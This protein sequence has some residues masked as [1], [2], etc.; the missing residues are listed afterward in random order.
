MVEQLIA[1]EEFALAD[2]PPDIFRIGT[3]IIGP[4]LIQ[5][6]RP[7]QKARFLPP[8]VSGEHLWCQGFSEPGA[9]SDLAALTT[10]AA[11]DGAGFRISGQK[12]WN[13]FGHWA[14]YCL[15]LVRTDPALPKHKGL[16]AFVVEMRTPGIQV[17][18]LVQI[19]GEQDFNELFFDEVHVREEA[20][21]GRL[22]GGWEVAV[23]MLGHERR[24]IAVI[25]F[26]CRQLYGRLLHLAREV[27]LGGRGI[28]AIDDA[29]VRSRL[30]RFGV[31]VRLIT[32]NNFRF[33][34]RIRHGGVPG[35]EGSIQKLQATELSKQM[36]AFAYELA[37]AGDLTQHG[38]AERLANWGRDYLSAFG[39]TIAGGTS[40]IQR[41]I[42]GERALGLP[43]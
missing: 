7:E 35:P 14:D 23:T 27:R 18:P 10:R 37:T 15:L 40:Q 12:V 30:A 6:G 28:A 22:N 21:V 19:N 34:E 11:R 24:G 16:T 8:M 31:Q 36:Y 3:R 9:G 41:N 13:T 5:L 32:L 29:R 25:G 38:T 26:A 1:F 33:A 42:I 39:M 17:R 20:I 43:K 2:A 4:M